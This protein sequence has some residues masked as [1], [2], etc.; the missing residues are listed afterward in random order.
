MMITFQILTGFVFIPATTHLDHMSKYKK[1][2]PAEIDRV[3]HRALDWAIG[4]WGREEGR[5][6]KMWRALVLSRL[7]SLAVDMGEG[8]LNE[9]PSEAAYD[10]QEMPIAYGRTEVAVSGTAYYMLSTYDNSLIFTR[11]V[12][13]DYRYNQEGKPHAGFTPIDVAAMEQVVLNV[14]NNNTELKN[15]LSENA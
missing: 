12:I 14:L 3:A 10:F 13:R 2:D 15:E 7:G 6:D 1:Y 11:C 5:N 8:E 4:S 9:I